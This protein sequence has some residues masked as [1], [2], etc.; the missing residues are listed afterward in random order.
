MKKQQIKNTKKAEFE[1]KDIFQHILKHQLWYILTLTIILLGITLGMTSQGDS[2][3]L[4]GSE[5]YYHLNEAKNLGWRNFQYAPLSIV[6]LLPDIVLQSLPFLLSIIFVTA[7]YFASL[8]ISITDKF[9]YLFFLFLVTSPVFLFRANTLSSQMFL[10]ILI[11]TGF[12]FMKKGYQRLSLT[13]FILV[14]FIDTFST[15]LLLGLLYLYLHSKKKIQ[16]YMKFYGVL[17][18]G[19]AIIQAVIFRRPFIL[20]PFQQDPSLLRL[21]S[22]LG[23]VSGLSVFIILLAAVGISVL[24]KKKAELEQYLLLVL[25]TLTYILNQAILL[26]LTIIL[27]YFATAGLLKISERPWEIKNLK[28]FT[29]FLLVL[30]ILFSATTYLERIGNVGPTVEDIKVLNWIKDNTPQD[31]IIFSSPEYATQINFFAEREAYASLHENLKSEKISKEILTSLYVTEAFPLLEKSKVS[32]IYIPKRMRED[33]PTEQGLIYLLQN[34][35]FK[36]IRSYGQ[37]EVWAFK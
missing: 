23:S 26:T 12:V 9:R 14:T 20:G 31:A 33:L 2:V 19:I 24:W 29:I 35:R 34:E 17:L 11:C 28:A 32:Y 30:G 8:Y 25:L 7:L 18:G 27:L 4:I 5:T 15:I 6:L 1:I 36:F 21:F 10:I 22:D 37:S 13:S 3:T 16:E